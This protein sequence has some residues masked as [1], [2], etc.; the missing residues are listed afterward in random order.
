MC[1]RRTRP[2]CGASSG[3]YEAT[4]LLPCVR[5]VRF[6]QRVSKTP[7]VRR[8]VLTAAAAPQPVTGRD[9]ATVNP[10]RLRCPYPSAE[11]HASRP[12]R[13]Y[14][15]GYVVSPHRAALATADSPFFSR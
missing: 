1:R 8:A 7:G 3:G 10:E 14:V 13:G 2:V 9:A 11:A 4:Q 12:S 15:G 6:R 5:G